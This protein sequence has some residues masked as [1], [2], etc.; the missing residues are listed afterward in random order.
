MGKEEQ[1]PISEPQT[2][3][4]EIWLKKEKRWWRRQQKLLL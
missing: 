4:G 3:E 1:P 2:E